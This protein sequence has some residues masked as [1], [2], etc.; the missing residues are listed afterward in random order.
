MGE[1]VGERSGEDLAVTIG[2]RLRIYFLEDPAF[3]PSPNPA[4]C[5]AG[6]PT[7]ARR[8]P[9][10]PGGDSDLTPR[11]PRVARLEMRPALPCGFYIS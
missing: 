9:S 4:G 10:L 8:S 6:G 2:G 5:S 7:P 1:G 11:V 3:P